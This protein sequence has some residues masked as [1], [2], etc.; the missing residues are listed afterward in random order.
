MRTGW[1]RHLVR[2]YMGRAAPPIQRNIGSPAA[3]PKTLEAVNSDADFLTRHAV[4]VASRF[5]HTAKILL[6]ASP[7]WTLKTTRTELLRQAV[8]E[9]LNRWAGREALIQKLVVA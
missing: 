6:A 7:V 5:H 9:I 2:T 4:Q 8:A 3:T 1:A